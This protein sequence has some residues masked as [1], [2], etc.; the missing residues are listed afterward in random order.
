M[1]K[2]SLSLLLLFFLSSCLYNDPYFNY[3]NLSGPNKALAVAIHTN[4]KKTGGT[5]WASGY[6]VDQAR[7]NAITNC[8]SYNLGYECIIELENNTNVLLSS[9]N[10]YKAEQE[11][12]YRKILTLRC[13]SYGFT[14]EMAIAKCV[15]QEIYNEKQIAFAQQAAAKASADA[16]RQ[17]RLNAISELG[18]QMTEMSKG[19]YGQK[20]AKICSFRSFEGAI[21]SGD[22][23][24]LT[25]DVGGTTYWKQ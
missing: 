21:I 19:N 16:L 17:Q 12:N 6:T 9:L 23:S 25:I 10:S 15:Q 8:R 14:N 3:N 18:K 7:A 2:K 22:C 1:F 13:K 24:M 4:G 11:L 20:P 5:G